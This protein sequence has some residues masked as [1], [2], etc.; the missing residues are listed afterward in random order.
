M[1]DN[2]DTIKQFI[3]A[4]ASEN[5]ADAHAHLKTVLYE[6]TKKRCAG[7]Y[8]KVKKSHRLNK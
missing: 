3:H 7:A 1:A 4:V 6:K 2:R 5:Y 8:E